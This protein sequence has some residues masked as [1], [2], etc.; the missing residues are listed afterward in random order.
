MGNREMWLMR[1]K[2]KYRSFVTFRDKTPTA[3]LAL[4]YSIKLKSYF[5]I[6]LSNM[7]KRRGDVL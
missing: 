3:G 7:L 1:R 5:E 4:L 2:T 6:S